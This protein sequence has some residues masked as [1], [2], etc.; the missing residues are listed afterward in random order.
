MLKNVPPEIPPELLLTLA[1]MGHGDRLA[2]VDRN[3]PAYAGRLPV[4]PLPGLTIPG[5]LRAILALLP[6]DTFEDPPVHFMT[7]DGE[8]DARLEVDDEPDHGLRDPATERAWAELLLPVLDGAPRI[9]DIGCGTGSL[10]VLLAR[11]GHQV[12]GIDFSP[13]M[14]ALATDKARGLDPEPEFSLGDASSPPLA[15]GAF[16]AVLCRHVLWALPDPATALAAWIRLLAPGGRLVLIEGRWSTGAGLT[17][18]VCTQLVGALRP[19]AELRPLTDPALWGGPIEDERYLLV[20][21]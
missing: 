14:L 1:E 4:Q 17:A 13:E 12:H 8:P 9:A 18:E 20:S 16:D 11:A 3:F 5:A 6:V 19:L 21:R 10:S 2:V 15:A 7:P